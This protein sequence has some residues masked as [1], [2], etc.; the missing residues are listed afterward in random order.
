M[1][2]VLTGT[3]TGK[4]GQTFPCGKLGTISV[5]LGGV[6]T[7]VRPKCSARQTCRRSLSRDRRLTVQQQVPAV[8]GRRDCFFEKTKLYAH[9]L[10]RADT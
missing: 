2:G 1:H 9:G 10:E 8:I 3:V 4:T 5:G 6:V 7:E